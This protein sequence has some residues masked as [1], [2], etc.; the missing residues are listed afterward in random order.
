MSIFIIATNAFRVKTV[1]VGSALTQHKP[2][3]GGANHD[4]PSPDLPGPDGRHTECFFL[5]CPV[6]GAHVMIHSVTLAVSFA[7][8][9]N[10][11]YS[12]SF[13]SRKT[14]EL[15]FD[16]NFEAL[17]MPSA[18]N[19]FSNEVIGFNDQFRFLNDVLAEH[20]LATELAATAPRNQYY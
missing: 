11:Y 17:L 13:V 8:F 6:R 15:V 20:L 10:N 5:V 1:S 7:A 3:I 19:H 2:R 18:A 14:F 4:Y 9:G 12:Q 16:K